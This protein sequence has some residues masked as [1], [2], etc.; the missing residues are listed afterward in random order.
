VFYKSVT[1]LTDFNPTGPNVFASAHLITYNQDNDWALF[2]LDDNQ[3]RF[4]HHLSFDELHATTPKNLDNLKGARAFTIGY[5]GNNYA[6]DWEKR[7][8]KFKTIHSP[9]HM[10]P[11]APN[12]ETSLFPGRKTITLGRLK[13]GKESKIAGRYLHTIS[14]WYGISG[15][16]IAGIHKEKGKEPHVKVFGLCKYFPFLSFPLEWKKKMVRK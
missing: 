13:G 5:N 10:P 6:N 12:M 11:S 1:F 7:S 2:K 16:F 9:S 15:G 8:E 14:G 4:Q 3:K